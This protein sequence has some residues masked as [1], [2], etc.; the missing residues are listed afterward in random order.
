MLGSRSSKA[1]CRAS[2][3][4]VT[5]RQAFTSPAEREFGPMFT[6]TIIVRDPRENPKKC[7]ILPLKDRIDVEIVSYPPKELLVAGR[8]HP[9]CR[10]R[11][12]AERRRSGRRHSAAGRKLRSATKMNARFTDVPPRSLAGWKS[13]YPR[14]SKLGTD[15]SNGLASV[16][17]STS[18]ITCSDVRPP[19]CSTT[20]A[21]RCSSSKSTD[22][23]LARTDTLFV[24]PPL[25]ASR[26]PKLPGKREAAGA[27]PGNLACTRSSSTR[28]DAVPRTTGEDRLRP[29]HR[30]DPQ[31]PLRRVPHQ[32][33][34]QGRVS[35]DTR[36]ELLKS[37]A[38]VP[39]KS[40]ESELHRARH[41][42]RPRD[43]H[44][45]QGDAARRR[46]RSPC[47]KAWIDQGSPGSRASRSR[48]APTSRR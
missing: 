24:D 42:R 40:G 32:R 37:K 34:V 27:A 15:P 4:I 16:E 44:A 22:S 19:G 5:V 2:F 8:L 30:A 35:L 1:N 20:I 26:S 33:Q 3:I 39:G 21:G 38:V 48:S 10:R 31:G 25:A 12:R 29:R 9:P 7:S 46:R 11:P 14:V 13:A 6:K 28:T 17:R 41:Q 47:C 45:A 43:P 23:R 18:R 36:E